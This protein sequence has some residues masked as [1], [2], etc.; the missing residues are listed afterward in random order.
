MEEIIM[1]KPKKEDLR[2]R[3]TKKLLSNALFE[4]IRKKPFEKIT[5]CD[6]CEEAMVHRATF[7]SH[8]SDKDELL[9]HSIDEHLPMTAADFGSEGASDSRGIVEG[10]INY[11]AD[12]RDVYTSIFKRNGAY[13]ISD[14][15][16]KMFSSKLLKLVT[17]RI[18]NGS[19][20]NV[21]PEFWAD[22]YAGACI[23]VVRKWLGGD[24]KVSKDEL[25]DNLNTLLLASYA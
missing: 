25:I 17:E 19:V 15:I 1:D 11:I 8:Y 6:I 23:S 16:Q 9:V 4:L 10:I 22:F 7:Y 5:V 12:N 21:S 18:K 2:V 14:R 13:S 3:R 20:V 24:L